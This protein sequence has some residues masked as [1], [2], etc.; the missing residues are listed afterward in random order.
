VSSSITDLDF[1]NN[2]ATV[3]AEVSV[4][5]YKEKVL[6]DLTMLRGIVSDKK[7]RKTLDDAIKHLSTSLDE[8]LWLSENTLVT[9]NG[10]N[11]FQSEKDA[12]VKLS[13]LIKRNNSGIA[14]TVQGFINR[15][16]AADRA[17]AD[18]AIYQVMSAHGNMN[19]RAATKVRITVNMS[20]QSYASK[21][22]GNMPSRQ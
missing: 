15:L 19:S 12:I 16:V 7:D 6:T 22:P 20:W 18:I 1:G 4:K 8:S 17:L 2:S 14:G 11:V 5:K 10:K 21:M 3:T 9:K 13:H